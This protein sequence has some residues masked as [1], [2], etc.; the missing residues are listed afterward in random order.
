MTTDLPPDVASL[1]RGVRV[2]L[3]RLRAPIA[4]LVDDPMPRLN[5]L[6][7]HRKFFPS[8]GSGQALRAARPRTRTGVLLVRTIPAA[9]LERFCDV[10]QAAG[11]RGKF[12]VVPD[13]FGL[14]EIDRGFRDCPRR[15]CA[16]FIETVRSRLMP[17]FDITPEMLTHGHAIDLD[18]G[19][20]L[21]ENEDAWSRKQGVE[22]LTRYLAHAAA[23]LQRAGLE[24][25]GFTSPWAFGRGVEHAYAEAALRA[26]Q[27]VNGRSLTWFFLDASERRRVMPRIMVVRRARRE[28][29]VHIVVGASDHLWE[30]QDTMR[31]DEPY[32]RERA[33]LF[34]TASGAGRIGELV[35]SGSFVGLLAHWQSLYSNG[36]EVGVEVLQRVLARINRLL[37]RRVAWMKC[38]EMTRYYAAAKAARARPTPDGLVIA[39]P[40][41]CPEFTISMLASRPPAGFAVDGRRLK[42]AESPRA[43]RTGAWAWSRGRAYL[44]FDLRGTAQIIAERPR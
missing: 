16:A 39:S 18:T 43:L 32:R 17:T 15:D 30:T 35:E 24:P 4:L 36:T 7:Y 11:A 9:F 40:F 41:A 21:P 13:P 10:V 5:P 26:Q 23:I 25:N 31:A 37:G 2:E 42:R 28:A 3:P 22:S 34:I 38:S 12:S 33:N 6:Y 1:G 44:C 8:T 19:R 27:Q 20:R 29:V 14:G